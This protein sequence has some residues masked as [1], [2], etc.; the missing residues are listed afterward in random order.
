MPTN[1]GSKPP[2]RCV[3][4]TGAGFT[5][6]F[7]GYLATQFWEHLFNLEAVYRNADLKRVLLDFQNNYDFEK[8]YGL[9]RKEGGTNFQL[10][11]SGLDAVYS[12]IDSL[13]KASLDQ[14]QTDIN[15]NDLHAWL[16]KF[17]GGHAKHGFVFT[18]NQDLF[19]ERHGIHGSEFIPVFPS[20]PQAAES[21]MVQRNPNI[22]KVALGNNIT[23]DEVLQHLGMLNVIKL[24]GSCN[25]L[26]A[27]D[28]NGAMALGIDKDQSI[29]KEPL[30]AHYLKLFEEVL[31]SG[32]VRQLWIVGYGYGDK[33][34]NKIIAR[35]TETKGVKLMII[36]PFRPDIFFKM[37]RPSPN[38][39]DLARA[40]NG[41]YPN[42]LHGTF[43][44]E[45]PKILSGKI[46]RQMELAH[47]N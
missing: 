11:M 12:E 29:E 37:L 38:G 6:N 36:H 17:G 19:L 1:I 2:H 47:E 15:I 25:W 42:T 5:H 34:I 46:K 44:W 9:L 45:G 39:D 35:A 3:L 8:I 16:G 13:V 40:L 24:H 22:V 26:S 28:G 27:L 43:P 14:S 30:L 10:Y 4:L 18:L 23:Y 31:M 21:H 33:H 41:Y 32:E 7:G 20:V